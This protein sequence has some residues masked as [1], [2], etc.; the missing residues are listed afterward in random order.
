MKILFEH[1]KAS[2]K[3]ALT[4]QINADKSEVILSGYG[5]QGQLWRRGKPDDVEWVEIP[6]VVFHA[7]MRATSQSRGNSSSLFYFSD[8][9]TIHK[10]Q[11]GT[12]GM[13]LIVQALQ[14][15][16]LK[17]DGHQ[18]EGFF[19]FAKQGR[20]IYFLPVTDEELLNQ[21]RVVAWGEVKASEN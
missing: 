20:E 1:P 17:V 19:T 18:I 13:L 3:W 21:C 9:D 16:I 4:K 2:K 6:N 14:D 12:K 10:Y 15:G 11:T 5:G 8:Q 7:K